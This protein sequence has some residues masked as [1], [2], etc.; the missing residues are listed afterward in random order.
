[1]AQIGK[2]EPVMNFSTNKSK[3]KS[4]FGQDG[5]Q[6]VPKKKQRNFVDSQSID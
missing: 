1:M 5:S 2:P 3:F 6:I 4:A